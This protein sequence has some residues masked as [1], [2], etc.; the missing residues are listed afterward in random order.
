M[1]PPLCA[2]CERDVKSQDGLVR[3]VSRATDL[4]W[5]ERARQPGF[6]GHPPDTDWFCAVHLSPARALAQAHT[7][8]AALATLRAAESG[9]EG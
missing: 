6:V 4:D 9:N 7:I 1:R 3:F 8:D 5:R 2:V